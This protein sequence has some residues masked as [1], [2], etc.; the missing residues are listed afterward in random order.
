[1]KQLFIKESFMKVL[2][3]AIPAWIF[4]LDSEWRVNAA[5]QAAREFMDSS[6]ENFLLHRCGSAIGCIHQNDDPRGCGFSL[7]C[8]D[9]VIRNTAIEAIHG[10]SVKR[11]KGK[12]AL[13]SGEEL[14][15]L[16][17]SSPVVYEGQNYSVTV[18][19]DISLI[20]E[21][22]GLIQICCSCNKILDDNGYWNRLER[23]IEEHS[24]AEF[25]HGICPDCIKK[26]YGD[27][28]KT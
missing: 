6:E 1:M 20:A 8:R 4:V 13:I 17:S 16:V 25:S 9:C 14:N 2:F 15:I 23:Y 21:L 22:Q 18:I 19:E 5:N 26:L 24:E 28:I 10:T 3:D 12:L 27:I 11:S 7:Y